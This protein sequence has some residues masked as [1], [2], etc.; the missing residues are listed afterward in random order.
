MSKF[1]IYKSSAGSGKTSRLIEVFLKLSLASNDAR[2]FKKILAITF[3]NKAA[4]EM[5]DRLIEEL[6]VLSNLPSDY[7]G[8]NYIVNNLLEEL[9]I[10]VAT[11]SSRASS[12]FKILL[13]D[14]NDLSI[15]TIDQFNH[16]LIRSFSRDLRLKSDFEVELDQK[17]LFHEAVERLIE[18]V[19]R[20]RYITE[21]LLGY[22]SLKLDDEKRVDIARDLEKM[23]RLI[24]DES[25]LEAIT[26]LKSREDIDFKEVRK[27]LYQ[28][29][30]AAQDAIRTKGKEVLAFL[31]QNNLSIDDFSRKASGYGGYFEKMTLYP[32]KAPNV[33]SYIAD[34]LE[35]KFLAKAAPAHL[36]S[37]VDGISGQLI[38][39]LT[40]SIRIFDENHRTFCLT[41]GLIWQVDLI[42]VLEELSAC[43]DE[44]CEERNILPI[45][46][47]NKLIS[48]ALRKE[49]VAYLYEHYGMR[50]DHILID[51][52][53]DTSELQ[54]FNIL[55]LIEESLAKG[56][57]SMVVGDAKQSIYRWRGG[58]AEQLIA[59]PE[60]IDAPDDL[61]LDAAETLRRT[62]QIEN[63]N[64][65]YR[66][67][68]N[69]IDFN[70]KLFTQ[71][72]DNLTEPESLY[73]SEY[74]KDNV[75][76]LKNK[77]QPD[78]Y[79]RID[80]LG[81][82]PEKDTKWDVLIKNIERFK[83]KGYA[84]GDMAII[85][86]STA[87]EGRL[88]LDRLQEAEIP[89]STAN[90]FEIDKDIEV[91]L[92]LAL[93]RLSYDSEN[94]QAK[95][96]VMRSMQGIFSLAFEPHRF[97]L[98]KG[99]DLNAFLRSHS[100][101]VFRP[102]KN[103]E[104]IYELT[105]RLIATYLPDSKNSFL[106]ALL[107]VIVG[108]VGL[109]GT[110]R[111]FFDWWD[112]VN[113]K[114]SVP[115]SEGSDAIQLTTIHKSKGLQYKVVFAPDLDWRFRASYQD[116]KWFDLRD[117]PISPIPFAP[118]PVSSKLIDMGLEAEW[119]RDEEETNFDNLNMVYVALTRAVD[120][121]C[122]SYGTSGKGNIGEALHTAMDQIRE[123]ELSKMDGYKFT[124][125]EDVGTIL[126]I[127]EI[128]AYQKPEVAEKEG[129]IIPWTTPDNAPWFTKV[130]TAPQIQ[131][132]ERVRGVR[133]HNVVS[134][135]K[136]AAQAKTKLNR[137]MTGGEIS[138]S[139]H[140]E[141][142]EMTNSLFSDERFRE[143]IES[144]K[145]RAERELYFENIILRPD[146][147]LENDSNTILIDFK[148][149]DADEKYEKQVSTYGV[150]LQEISTKPVQ[151]FLVY[152]SPVTWVKVE[153][154][155]PHQ[156]TLFD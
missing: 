44:I 5:K 146:L 103:A 4:A 93:L 34:A 84:Y 81:K 37:L 62:Q 133:F 135:S 97:E 28:K 23:Q 132:P 130:L 141:L 73:K 54:W 58:K 113:E 148:T 80:Y 64:T 11:L 131:D 26:V 114:P 109:N 82:K 12:T 24:L 110:C 1:L 17:N 90:S 48:E 87:K 18:K 117:H 20:D 15:G 56:K 94:T 67:R 100:K 91:R 127:G 134:V 7:P 70:N 3:T 46:K 144:S 96:S 75:S 111:G 137:W 43:L 108:R 150:A 140:E 125:L 121:L 8:D 14:Y 53:Q 112:T 99:I 128:P 29:R 101:P 88:I 50:F 38:D 2:R 30:K 65:N 74:E 69:V 149:G 79:V 57:T 89:V 66:S 13:H 120:A 25:G 51:E 76:Q 72:G 107:N 118:L 153:I 142:L 42:A 27:D 68:E 22:M 85:V 151:A 155:A 156:K 122:I 83:E 86:R 92:I 47:F 136:T 52:Y 129:N 102:S 41:N 49:P 45:S 98:K 21:H 60:L 39:M 138:L 116:L 10:D 119:N 145:A 33:N 115:G 124:D 63:L 154:S 139:E 6:D 61:K 31:G 106:N 32:E 95:I 40:E 152:I 19:G 36:Y 78:G 9:E 59:L 105:E 143:L 77:R 35:G 104:G 71:L 126:E 147:V 123:S 16:R 55:P